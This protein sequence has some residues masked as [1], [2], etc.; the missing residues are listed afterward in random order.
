MTVNRAKRAKAKTKTLQEDPIFHVVNSKM[1]LPKSILRKLWAVKRD[2]RGKIPVLII[3][4]REQGIK[5]VLKPL[6]RIEEKIKKFKEH[7]LIA[8]ALEHFLSCRRYR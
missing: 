1:K 6:T 4:D 8:L 2:A 5:V 3:H 7:D